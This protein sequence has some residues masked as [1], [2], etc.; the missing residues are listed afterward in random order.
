MSKFAASPEAFLLAGGVITREEW[1]AFPSERRIAYASA[2]RTIRKAFA[3]DVADAVME[4]LGLDKIEDAAVA[5]VLD[6]AVSAATSDGKA[7]SA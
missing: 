6:A 2:G 3:E 5:K 1:A 7:A 4:R